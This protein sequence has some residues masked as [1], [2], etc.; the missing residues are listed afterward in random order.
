MLR[1]K[2]VSEKESASG[3]PVSRAN[4]SGDGCEISGSAVWRRYA[5]RTKSS[6]LA[7]TLIFAEAIA[8]SVLQ[9]GISWLLFLCFAGT[10]SGVFRCIEQPFDAGAV[11]AH[12][13]PSTQ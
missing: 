4:R 10:L 2:T 5:F 8:R 9:H 11:L 3:G 1:C 13:A 6:V 7:A 12:A